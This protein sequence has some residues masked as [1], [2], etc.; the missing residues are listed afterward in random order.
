[1]ENQKVPF[2]KMLDSAQNGIARDMTCL[3]ENAANTLAYFDRAK[4]TNVKKKVCNKRNSN[5]KFHSTL[6]THTMADP[7]IPGSNPTSGNF[8]FV[9]NLINSILRQK[10]KKLIG[11]HVLNKLMQLLA[12]APHSGESEGAFLENVRFGTKWDC[13]G[14]DPSD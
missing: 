7:K 2:K 3:I 4:V 8:F 12:P 13:K 1:M 14:H 9:A 11:V 5:I 10:G 6:V